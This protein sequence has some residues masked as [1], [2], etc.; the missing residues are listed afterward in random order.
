MMASRKLDKAQWRPFFDRVSKAILGMRAEIE[1]DSL[2]LGSQ[3]E[4]KADWLPLLGI[5]YDH[6]DDI[7]EIALEDLDHLIRN[8]REIHVDEGVTGLE[9]LM[10]VS[11]DGVR[12]IV[13]LRD[14]LMLPAPSAAVS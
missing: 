13:K 4:V 1:V 9:S 3:L 10:V 6:K 7:L 14:P 11:A 12:Q 5:V 2:E 8:P